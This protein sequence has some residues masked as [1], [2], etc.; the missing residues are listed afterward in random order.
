MI[1]SHP[2]YEIIGRRGEGFMWFTSWI[3]KLLDGKVSQFPSPPFEDVEYRNVRQSLYVALLFTKKME[4]KFRN[5][6]DDKS[7]ISE[8]SE[9]SKLT[10]ELSLLLL[11]S[12]P[13]KKLLA[14]S[15]DI[16]QYSED[17]LTAEQF[18]IQFKNTCGSHVGAYKHILNY[19]GIETAMNEK[20]EKELGTRLK[21]HKANIELLSVEL[22]KLVTASVVPLNRKDEKKKIRCV[23]KTAT[24]GY[25]HRLEFRCTLI[26]GSNNLFSSSQIST[27]RRVIILTGL[28]ASTSENDIVHGLSRCGAVDACVLYPLGVAEGKDHLV[29]AS[30]SDAGS[31]DEDGDDLFDAVDDE[32]LA[33]DRRVGKSGGSWGAT[34]PIASLARAGGDIP[35]LAEGEGELAGGTAKRTRGLST[36]L[37]VGAGNNLH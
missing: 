15:E 36:V 9:L 23:T 22:D 7:K 27:S 19:L 6:N 1:I 24:V 4:H 14:L 12:M 17:R 26:L 31:A 11:K 13:L 20:I 18:L 32:A 25:C 21:R 3:K 34:N 2:K 5:Y 35:S 37:K 16:E 30:S 10:E 29:A 28:N 33:I 8:E